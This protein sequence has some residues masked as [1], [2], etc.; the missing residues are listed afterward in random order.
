VRRGAGGPE[1]SSPEGSGPEESPRQHPEG[2]EEGRGLPPAE[3]V[4]I[5]DSPEA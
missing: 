5:S 3:G 2:R 4:K 1:G